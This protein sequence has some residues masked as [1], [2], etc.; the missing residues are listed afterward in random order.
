MDRRILI[1]LSLCLAAFGGEAFAQAPG[2]STLSGP[3]LPPPRPPFRFVPSLVAVPETDGAYVRCPDCAGDVAPV[4]VLRRDGVT[5]NVSARPT[6]KGDGATAAGKTA[7]TVTIQT[8]KPSDIDAQEDFITLRH[9]DDNREFL[10]APSDYKLG[11]YNLQDMEPRAASQTHW[12]DHGQAVPRPDEWPAAQDVTESS[13]DFYIGADLLSG[14]FSVQLP[15]IAVNGKLYD[16]PPI[17]FDPQSA[18]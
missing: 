15:K 4:Y 3:P 6:A 10:L 13:L 11:I 18:P 2:V 14:S 8:A 7:I 16:I 17:Q 12:V 9:K 5:F 1:A